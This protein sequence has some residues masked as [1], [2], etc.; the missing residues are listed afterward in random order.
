VFKGKATVTKMKKLGSIACL[1]LAI[2]LM[3]PPMA[4]SA[5]PVRGVWSGTETKYWT[6][7]KWQRYSENIPFSFRVDRGT[8]LSFRTISAYVWP[9]C[10]GGKTVTAKLPTTRKANVRNGQ[11]RGH[12]TTHVGSRK[13]TAYVSG[14]FA[15]AHGARGKIVVKL[16][17]CPAYRS[18]W[19]AT[20]GGLGGV[21]IPICRG[22]N[23]LMPD[24][25]YYYN[26]CAYI[27]GRS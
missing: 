6:G 7:S 12:R 26:S 2:G 3:A 11:F 27:A 10:T 9:G 13:M 18:V 4:E 23:I 5:S 20:S 8:V 16:A 22:Q 1:A 17:G 14:R 15:S 21:H 25:S 24:G 19:T